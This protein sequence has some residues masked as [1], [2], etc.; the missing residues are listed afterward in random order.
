MP[1]LAPPRTDANKAQSGH[2]TILRGN[3]APG[4][5]VAKLTGK[6]G[7]RFEGTARVFDRL[8][9]FY[10]ALANGDITPGTVVIFRYMG[11][12]GAPGMPEVRL[13]LA[14]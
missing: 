14:S 13:L 9:D 8:D 1:P 5:A 4:S 12:K 6:E 10:P 11:P 7:D 2:L 3:L